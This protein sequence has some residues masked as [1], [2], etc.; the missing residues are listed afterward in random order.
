[1]LL[2]MPYA[3]ATFRMIFSTSELHHLTKV[4]P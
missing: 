3:P 2:V 4:L 1:M